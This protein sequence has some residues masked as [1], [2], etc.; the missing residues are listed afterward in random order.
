[1]T[2]T[3][4]LS[5]DLMLDLYIPLADEE[6]LDKEILDKNHD[7]IDEKLLKYLYEIED[8]IEPGTNTLE[9]MSTS[10]K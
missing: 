9:N 7:L 1:M 8:G 2:E 4:P 6:I 5:M 3:E 10:T